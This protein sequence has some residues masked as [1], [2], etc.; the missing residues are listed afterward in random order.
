VKTILAICD[1]ID[2]MDPALFGVFLAVIMLASLLLE[3]RSRP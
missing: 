3:R 2:G 1:Y